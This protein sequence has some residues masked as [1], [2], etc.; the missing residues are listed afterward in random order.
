M[1]VL[2]TGGLSYRA[3]DSGVLETGK[4]G[5]YD[6]WDDWEQGA[7]P[8]A[9]VSAAVLAANPHDTQAW[10]FRVSPSSVDV[11]ADRGR[12]LGRSTRSSGSGTRAS[13]ARWR[14]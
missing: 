7:G 3:Y 5:A 11:F 9:L 12:S 14:T 6:A 2:S 13:A 4:G 1:L 8:L 10:L